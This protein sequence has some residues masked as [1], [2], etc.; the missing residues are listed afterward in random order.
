M[1]NAIRKQIVIVQSPE[2]LWQALTDRSALAEW[3]YP[4]DFEPRVGHCFTFRVPP[5]PKV[6][7]DAPFA[8]RFS[9]A[10]RRAGSRTRGRPGASWARKSAIASRA[11]VTAHAFSSSTRAS[12]SLSHG[13]SR[14][15]RER[16][17]AGRKCSGSCPR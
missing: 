14:R 6:G 15:S 3:M 4:N 7:F 1:S 17:L 11:K 2:E 5:N 10:R 13:A 8:A 12:I 9:S 16:S